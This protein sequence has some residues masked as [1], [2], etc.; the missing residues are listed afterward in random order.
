MSPVQAAIHGDKPHSN[1]QHRTAALEVALSHVLHG[2]FQQG[3]L[4]DIFGQMGWHLPKE[5][6]ETRTCNPKDDG[7]RSGAVAG[8]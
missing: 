4:L 5:R 2:Q 1:A 6:L 8:A 7:S 3:C